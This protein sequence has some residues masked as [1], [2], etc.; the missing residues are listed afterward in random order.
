MN[1]PPNPPEQLDYYEILG[2]N[3]RASYATIE[4]CH[5]RLQAS[6][7]PDSRRVGAAPSTEHFQNAG[8]AWDTLESD[9]KR[10][11][12]DKSYPNIRKQWDVYRINLAKWNDEQ[13]EIA[14]RHARAAARQQ[15][16]R[17]EN[18]TIEKEKQRVLEEKAKEATRR[19]A[20]EANHR[21][22]MEEGIRQREREAQY[23]KERLQE[24]HRQ[25]ELARAEEETRIKADW[26]KA[27]KERN[28]AK[29][30]GSS[31]RASDEKDELRERWR[32]AEDRTKEQARKAG[33][34]NDAAANERLRKQQEIPRPNEDEHGQSTR[35]AH[36]ES[37]ERER[38]AKKQRDA[39]ERQAKVFADAQKRHAEAAEE[40]L[41]RQENDSKSLKRPTT[42][43]VE[44]NMAN[45]KTSKVETATAPSSRLRKLMALEQARRKHSERLREVGGPGN[46][47]KLRDESI[48]LGWKH[49]E[50][51]NEPCPQCYTKKSAAQF[52]LWECPDGGALRCRPCLAALSVFSA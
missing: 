42:D 8:I 1:G 21:N 50:Y 33:R 49:V 36:N 43:D 26:V 18:M 13:R 38:L 37:L 51:Q 30:F 4:R 11:R 32:L 12:Y 3:E 19:R 17:E 34:M 35:S 44:Q 39:D 20:R 16:V 24:E 28:V 2:V 40:R 29:G 15:K 23:A 48:E 10:A 46:E 22:W 5:K 41:R 7:H 25:Q 27:Q 47:E 6:Y 14:Q 9:G 31:P 52:G 45:A